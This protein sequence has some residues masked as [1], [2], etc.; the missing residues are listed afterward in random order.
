MERSAGAM[1]MRDDV[2]ARGGLPATRLTYPNQSNVSN[3]R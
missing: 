3:G 1:R 2:V